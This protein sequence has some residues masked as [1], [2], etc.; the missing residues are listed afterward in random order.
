[1]SVYKIDPDK[2][3]R[4]P[5]LYSLGS[6]LKKLA[7]TE[8]ECP[9]SPQG[10][11]NEPFAGCCGSEGSSGDGT[12]LSTV[13][14]FMV[15]QGLLI[16]NGDGTFTPVCNCLAPGPLGSNSSFMITDEGTYYEVTHDVG[17]GSA[18]FV[19]PLPGISD[20]T[21]NLI[22]LNPDGG[23][24]V[25]CANII[26]ECGFVTSDSTSS[27]SVTG[28]VNGV[29]TITHDPG[30]GSGP[31]DYPININEIDMDIN[32]VSITGSVVTFTAEDGAEVT[33]DICA[34][35][36]ANCNSALIMTDNAA[37]GMPQLEF[38]DN[39][40]T[41]NII[42]LPCCVDSVES[43]ADTSTW[44][45][46][47]G[48]VITNIYDN[49]GDMLGYVD[50][51]GPHP[52]PSEDPSL[53]E[54]DVDTGEGTHTSS[55]GTEVDFATTSAD[56]GNVLT[57]G[58]NGGS[59][60]CI[61]TD[62]C[63]NLLK[64]DADGCLEVKG[65]RTVCDINIDTCS[66]VNPAAPTTDPTALFTAPYIQGDNFTENFCGNGWKWTYDCTASTFV[67]CIVPKNSGKSLCM[68]V[69][70]K[71]PS[72][73][74]IN[75]PADLLVTTVAGMLVIDMDNGTP[76]VAPAMCP[77]DCLTIYA[78]NGH[79]TWCMGPDCML[80]LCGID[81][82]V[83]PA[84][85]ISAVDGC[86]DDPVFAVNALAGEAG[87]HF[88]S[89]V[90]K[91]ADN[92]TVVFSDE[93]PDG[94]ALPYD[95][96]NMTATF[97]G[98]D[99]EDGDKVCARLLDAANGNV[100]ASD[101]LCINVFNIFLNEGDEK[102]LVECDGTDDTLL[103]QTLFPF[104][105]ESDS[106]LIPD[107]AAWEAYVSGTCSDAVGCTC[108]T[109]I[110]AVSCGLP[111]KDDICIIKVLPFVF[112]NIQVE[113][114]CVDGHTSGDL[115][116]ELFTVCS[117]PIAPTDGTW[118][119]YVQL[120]GQ[121]PD[122]FSGGIA[123]VAVDGNPYCAQFPNSPGPGS[124]FRN[125]IRQ[126]GT[127]DEVCDERIL[128]TP[129]VVVGAGTITLN[130]G[131]TEVHPEYQAGAD[132]YTVTVRCYDLNGVLVNEVTETYTEGTTPALAGSCATATDDK[133]F[134]FDDSSF[135]A[136]V[137]LEIQHNYVCPV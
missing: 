29:Y 5:V 126:V 47:P 17:D 21:G 103:D 65:P 42:P 43:T 49:N 50:G 68:Q 136:S 90:L 75:Q 135:Q 121:N 6:K 66:P 16:D 52:I 18:P 78:G 19:Y 39:A 7:G 127:T 104:V 89:Y 31:T 88:Q 84:I 28:P 1:M 27:F 106:T 70:G 45:L 37:T 44:T 98:Q 61:N 25:Q 112:A 56:T 95:I 111:N 36:A 60:L 109:Y 92:V 58:A 63:D 10:R 99:L 134:T 122:S 4:N 91:K 131:T 74:F 79:I 32:N 113:G 13:V 41:T 38:T 46:T 93:T 77:N 9:E 123:W 59:H 110:R 8:Q 86:V 15:D 100:I 76:L 102:M 80:T 11:G 96:A 108:D 117:Q 51:N 81:W 57:I 53:F 82:Q 54:F 30:D 2:D 62:D 72:V 137:T 23:M 14:T 64:L 115:G 35:V 55:D 114:D 83:D 133:N 3:A 22:A 71:L 107:Q 105:V 116:E 124:V 119:Q 97:T 20:A 34:I 33:V 128:P 87:L 129:E 120:D 118:E 40:G 125:C 73:D 26:A 67:K 12:N 48:S 69:V 130:N 85:K 94:A 132:V 24:E 101:E